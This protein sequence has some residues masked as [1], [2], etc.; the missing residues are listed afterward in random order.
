MSDIGAFYGPNAGYVLELY[1]QYLE[2]PASV[3]PRWQTYFAEFQPE[4]PV[5]TNGHAAAVAGAPAAPS[6]DLE[7]VV[8]AAALAQAIREYGHLDAS[9]DPLQ[10]PVAD[11]PD[12]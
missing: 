4:I 5:S 6:V 2:D 8:G 9:I 7:K 3:A 11:N 1:E 12:L 10:R